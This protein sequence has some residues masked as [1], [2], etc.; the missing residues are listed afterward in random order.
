MYN[1][2]DG[3]IKRLERTNQQQAQ[4]AEDWAWYQFRVSPTCP[5]SQRVYVRGGLLWNPYPGDYYAYQVPDATCDLCDAEQTFANYYTQD[6][7]DYTNTPYFVWTNAYYYKVFALL[8]RLHDFDPD[9]L[10]FILCE[11]EDWTA[12]YATAAEAEAAWSGTLTDWQEAWYTD[13]HPLCGLILR[14]DGRTGTGC[15]FQPVD[16]VN[17]GGS[18][19]WPRDIR[20][21][22][23]TV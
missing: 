19:I 15:Y 10:T 5:P 21:L 3:R 4:R 14:N 13:A 22:D 23:Y 1:V 7:W 12:E 17:R 9:N 18:Y 6:N 8:L 20:P 16:V 2:L 11:L